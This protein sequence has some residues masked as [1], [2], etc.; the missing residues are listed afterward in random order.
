MPTVILACC[1]AS[2]LS[3]RCVLAKQA[4]LVTG[5]LYSRA[6][7]RHTMSHM[8]HTNYGKHDQ[9][10][11][12]FGAIVWLEKV[13]FAKFDGHYSVERERE[14]DYNALASQQV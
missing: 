12:F 6:K 7:C 10:S 11:L 8:A 9:V 4:H 13:S 14:R 1:A 3:V 2:S 5:V